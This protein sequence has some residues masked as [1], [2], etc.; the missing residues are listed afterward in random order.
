MSEPLY[1]KDY[2]A[3]MDGV[4]KL[5]LQRSTPDRL[6]YLADWTGGSLKHKMDHLVCFVPGM[7][8][9]GAYRHPNSP[10]AERD[11]RVAKQLMYTCYQMYERQPTGIAPELVRRSHVS[12]RPAPCNA[13]L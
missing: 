1:R 5:L 3:A 13:R 8:A 10:N 7:L 6:A 9:L 2:D 4:M 12:S 11:L